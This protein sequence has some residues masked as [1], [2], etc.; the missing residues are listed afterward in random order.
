MF[1]LSN[2]YRWWLA[3][4]LIFL[5]LTTLFFMYTHVGKIWGT[6]A[7]GGFF[8]PLS[9]RADCISETDEKVENKFARPLR[10][11]EDG[12][13]A[14]REYWHYAFYRQCLYN[15][16]YAFS[17]K[18]LPSSSLIN[19]I[20]SNAL[21]GFSTTLPIES[22]LLH[23]NLLDVE[24]DY[25]LYES[26]FTVGT[27]S[28][29]L[30]LYT[31]FDDVQDQASLAKQLPS[32]LDHSETDLTIQPAVSSKSIDYH[33]FATRNQQCGAAFYTPHGRIIILAYSC[34]DRE[35][36]SQTVDAISY[37]ETVPSLH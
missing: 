12:I 21:A 18:A 9:V 11:N 37:F 29:K 6:Y 30:A 26:E 31:S 32:I 20:Y 5:A 33:T 3:G 10:M 16:G 24:V 17:G 22:A 1:I 13:T 14:L 36:H 27:S 19:G 28:L 7:V 8:A 23:D 4:G 2:R 15:A 34:S 25:R 35:L